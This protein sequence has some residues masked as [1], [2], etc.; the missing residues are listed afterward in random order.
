M[1]QTKQ[2]GELNLSC[3]HFRC[4][5]SPPV[6]L[7]VW[8]INAPLSA[9]EQSFQSVWI[10][11]I[12]CYK[13]WFW[14]FFIFWWKTLFK[15]F[16]FFFFF[17]LVVVVNCTH[18]FSVQQLSWKLLIPLH[19]SAR[20]EVSIHDGRNL[21]RCQPGFNK[22]EKMMELWMK[23]SLWKTNYIWNY[24]IRQMFLFISFVYQVSLTWL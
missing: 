17:P 1:A 24:Y 3:L 5:L 18:I 2:K 21:L 4:V 23:S 14:H 13:K 12:Q 20:V 9:F 6:F 15:L 10:W 8:E 11:L 7:L 16:S 22:M 19:Q